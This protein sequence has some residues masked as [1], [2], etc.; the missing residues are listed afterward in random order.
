MLVTIVEISKPIN[1]AFLSCIFHVYAHCEC[2]SVFSNSLC[3]QMNSRT[4]CINLV[5][6]PCAFFNISSNYLHNGMYNYISPTFPHCVFLDEFSQLIAVDWLYSTM[7]F[8]VFDQI[9]FIRGYIV[10]LI[11]FL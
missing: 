2:P 8:Q 7:R 6:L 9:V 5:F 3:V 4:D 11:A 10:T 1:L